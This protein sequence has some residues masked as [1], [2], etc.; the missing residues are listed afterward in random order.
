MLCLSFNEFL[1]IC[2]RTDKEDNGNALQDRSIYDGFSETQT[3]SQ[4]FFATNTYY[5]LS[6]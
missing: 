4:V 6:Y 1:L 3:E 2:F 5:E